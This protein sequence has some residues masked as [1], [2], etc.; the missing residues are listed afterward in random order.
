MDNTDYTGLEVF[1]KRITE[2]TGYD[3]S[4]YKEK[5][6]KRRIRVILRKHKLDNVKELLNYFYLHPDEYSEIVK[7]ITINVTEFFRNI[8][9]FTE[10][11]E[12]IIKDLSQGH[13]YNIL[14]AGC[15]TGEEPYSIAMIIEFIKKSYNITYNIS[16]IDIDKEAI[17]KTQIAIYPIEEYKSIP[18]KYKQYVS[19]NDK[20]FT[21]NDCIKQNVNIATINLHDIDSLLD[22]KFNIIV[23]RNVFIYFNKEFQNKITSKFYNLL[24][25]DGYLILGKVE[26]LSSYVKDKFDLI[27]LTN[28]IYRKK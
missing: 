20:T 15:A 10:I 23:C 22:L 19:V 3:F 6:L 7:I 8:E 13:R 5:P 26:T 16:A 1:I 27:D 2:N 18:D 4:G 17:K 9:V 11:E 14:S 24:K 25:T 12:L 28:R 21:I